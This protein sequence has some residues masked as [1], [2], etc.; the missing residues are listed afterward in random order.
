MDGNFGDHSVKEEKETSKVISRE[1]KRDREG[2]NF[3]TAME[4]GSGKKWPRGFLPGSSSRRIFVELRVQSLLAVSRT[5]IGYLELISEIRHFFSSRSAPLHL[6]CDSG[7]KPGIAQDV[8]KKIRT[9]IFITVAKELSAVSSL[10]RPTET[11]PGTKLSA[12]LRASSEKPS[13]G[14]DLIL[15][16]VCPRRDS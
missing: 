5:P 15:S 7:K 8:G 14:D 1:R 2:G 12:S 16:V 3:K 10:L 13:S 9:R 6:I 4:E 11:I